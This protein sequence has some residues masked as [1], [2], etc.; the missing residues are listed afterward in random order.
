M[1]DLLSQQDI[2]NL[3]AGINSGSVA[4]S[5]EEQTKPEAKG[6]DKDAVTFDFRLPHRLSKNQMRTLQAIHE[7][8]A[9]SFS[10]YLISRLQTTVNITLASIDQLFYSEFVLS[11]GN[12]SSLF[13]FR[14]VENDAL[15][16]LE[17]SPQLALS[18]VSRLLGGPIGKEKKA[19][20][21]TEIEQTIVRGITQRAVADLQKAWKTI[22]PLTFQIER[23]ETEGEFIQIAPASEIVLLVSLEVTVGDQKFMMNVCFPTFALEDELTKINTQGA[24]AGIAINN[25]KK[26]WS[27]ILAQKVTQTEV[28]VSAVLGNASITMKEFLRLEIGDVVKTNISING[29]VQLNIGG[30]TRFY[31]KPGASNGHLAIR[32]ERG[33]SQQ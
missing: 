13:V 19:R 15:A 5:S 6:T 30:A 31:G 10:S 9:E 7:S 1:A 20:L 11:I 3:L 2:D 32:I 17:I 24:A 25:S 27:N 4:M 12:P 26:E 18:M 21:L 33:N 22:A 16:V 29:D 28:S 23:Y 8:F 14:I